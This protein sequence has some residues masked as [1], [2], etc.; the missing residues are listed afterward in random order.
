MYE[1]YL[2]KIKPISSFITPWQSDTIY[3]HFL[4]GI[5][6]LYGDNEVRKV[7]DDFKKL[8]SPFIISDGFIDGK[9]PFLKKKNIKREK[10]KIF[11]EKLSMTLGEIVKKEKIIN[12]ISHINLEEF[13]KLRGNYT[14]EEFVLDK[15][16]NEEVKKEQISAEEVVM[17]NIINRCSGTTAENGLFFSK[18]TFTDK[19]IYIFIKIRKDYSV[20]KIKEIIKFVEGNGYGK[21]SS[22]GKGDFKTVSLEKFDGFAEIKN[23]DG[24]VV[25]S[26]YI[27]KEFD[28]K[29]IVHETP[30]IKF[31]KIGSC[32]R[33][34]E[35]PFKK[36]FACFRAGSIFRKGET[37]RIGKVLEDIHFD[38]NIVQIGIPFV[39]EVKL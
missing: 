29:E 37:E 22:T 1:T 19:E 16:K 23:A 15:L 13:N 27:P 3:G 31:A 28:Y 4:W 32:G 39:L 24:F 12:K 33:N 8:N 25:L 6:L 7:I 9:L 20:E 11:A 34:A 35:N 10:N 18:E 36:P 2:W 26:N 5:S 30:L 21:K 17:H 38:K 14:N